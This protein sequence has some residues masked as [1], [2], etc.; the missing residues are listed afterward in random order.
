L[1]GIK[2]YPSNVGNI[3]DKKDMRILDFTATLE[4]WSDRPMGTCPIVF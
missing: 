2:G 4:K 1:K 3:D